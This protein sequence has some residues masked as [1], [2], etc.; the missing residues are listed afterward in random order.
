MQNLNQT[1]LLI[2]SIHCLSF[3]CLYDAYTE[4][5]TRRE[6]MTRDK[7]ASIVRNCI[8]KLQDTMYSSTR[9]KEKSGLRFPFIKDLL[10]AR[11]SLKS[12][13]FWGT[14]ITI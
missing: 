10:I 6:P 7:R 12:F 14:I 1:T 11:N 2:F 9:G 3:Q 13:D 4:I 5:K 8:L